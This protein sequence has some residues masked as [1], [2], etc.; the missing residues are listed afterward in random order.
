MAMPIRNFSSRLA[1][2][3]QRGLRALVIAL[4]SVVL[5]TWG[6]LW[7]LDYREAKKGAFLP[8]PFQ[9]TDFGAISVVP[10][11]PPLTEFPCKPVSEAASELNPDELVLGVEV[12]GEARAY[13]IN[14][15]TGPDREILND[16]LG[17]RPIAATW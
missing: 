1:G 10:P 4:L 5:V 2:G 8:N 7:Y 6:T 9:L 15:L 13:P 14:M 17:G 11:Q 16:T 3:L 12:G